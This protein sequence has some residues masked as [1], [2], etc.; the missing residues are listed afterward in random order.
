MN[1]FHFFSYQEMCKR[2]EIIF[3]NRIFQCSLLKV[4]YHV[5]LAFSNL[6][7]T[8]N[9]PFICYFYIKTSFLSQSAAWDKVKKVACLTFFICPALV[10]M[11][12]TV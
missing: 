12:A 2:L 4:R 11:N 6:S 7:T 1:F 8:K 9:I 3:N 5:F 10:P